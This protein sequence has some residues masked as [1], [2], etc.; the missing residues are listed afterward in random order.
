MFYSGYSFLSPWIFVLKTS[1][2]CFMFVWFRAT[3]PR[4]KYDQLLDLCWKG[5]LPVIVGYICL[6]PTI[7]VTLTLPL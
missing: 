4:L 7:L 3:L 5:L 6:V 2:I 1:L